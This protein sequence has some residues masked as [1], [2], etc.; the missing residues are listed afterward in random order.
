MA[1][2]N[3]GC[4]SSR[5]HA[6][7][8]LRRAGFRAVVAESFAEIFAGNCTNLGVACATADRGTLAA[9]A[10][11]VE[12]APAEPVTVDLETLT[13]THGPFAAAVRMADSAR[14]ALLS[15]RYDFLAQLLEGSDAVEKTAGRLP[16]LTG[17]PA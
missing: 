17:F 5:E 9:L 8:S 13:V 11:S 14:E 10:A 15:G 7:Q 1:G 12:S 3:F 16:Y 4:G 2:R 6:P